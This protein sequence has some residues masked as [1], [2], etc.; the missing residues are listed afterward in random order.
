MISFSIRENIYSITEIHNILDYLT[1]TFVDISLR[2][3]SGMLQCHSSFPL[4]LEYC[5]IPLMNIFL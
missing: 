2:S 3:T 4:E 5:M 1:Y